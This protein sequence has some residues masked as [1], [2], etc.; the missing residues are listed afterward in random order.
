MQAK[1][2]PHAH[3]SR[4]TVSVTSPKSLRH[5]LPEAVLSGVIDVG[6]AVSVKPPVTPDLDVVASTVYVPAASIHSS[7]VVADDGG[8]DSSTSVAACAPKADV[9]RVRYSS[10]SPAAEVIEKSTRAGAD[11]VKR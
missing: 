5:W 6:V 2:A 3:E 10:A 1:D 4:L 8:C 9:P 11:S 7:R